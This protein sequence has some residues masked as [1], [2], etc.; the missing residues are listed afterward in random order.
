MTGDWT[1][2]TLR[3]HL[4]ALI[5]ANDRRYE[6]RA[7]DAQVAIHTAEASTTRRFESTNEW[8]ALVTNQQL[9]FATRA[10][11]QLMVQ[12]NL[13]RITKLEE[14]QLAEMARRRGSRDSM[15]WIIG[16]ISAAV[17]VGTLVLRLVHP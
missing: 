8:R 1:T 9:T 14:A 7:E 17:A 11:V 2:D 16:A 13:Q 6:Q 3:V 10:E 4:V 12:S 15:G 5:D